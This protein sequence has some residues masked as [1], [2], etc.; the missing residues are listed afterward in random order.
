[1]NRTEDVNATRDLWNQ[2]SEVVSAQRG[3]KTSHSSPTGALAVYGST[4]YDGIPP[5]WMD[6]RVMQ[7]LAR[8][9][10][11][12]RFDFLG[13]GSRHGIHTRGGDTDACRESWHGVGVS[14][15]RPL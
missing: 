11:Q 15:A 3:W 4:E 5:W 10:R 1:M 9:H 7:G 2:D 6:R 12:W 13:C 8:L 14:R